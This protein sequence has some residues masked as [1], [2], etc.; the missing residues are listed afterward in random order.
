MNI[1]IEDELRDQFKEFMYTQLQ[2]NILKK[3]HLSTLELD[4]MPDDS[5]DKS[6]FKFSLIKC[7]SEWILEDTDES[8]LSELTHH[9]V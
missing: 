2:P 8:I 4:N 7:F 9:N 5:K 1:V 6:K 3:L